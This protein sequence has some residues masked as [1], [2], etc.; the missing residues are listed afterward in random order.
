MD[1]T[2]DD[3][4][5]Q[6]AVV[7]AGWK[8]LPIELQVSF[9]QLITA[10]DI[11]Q[12]KLYSHSFLFLQFLHAPWSVANGL[13]PL[14]LPTISHLTGEPK[15]GLLSSNNLLWKHFFLRDFDGSI[16]VD[17]DDA[18]DWKGIYAHH[19]LIPSW[20]PQ[21]YDDSL[22]IVENGRGLLVKRFEFGSPK[23][24]TFPLKVKTCRLAFK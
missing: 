12:R 2:S 5:S 17:D 7:M 4:D 21:H 6:S 11:S 1:G 24:V 8:D 22:A 23:A 20:D 13:F 3:R 10:A 19:T 15:R 16:S 18:K 9:K 14:F